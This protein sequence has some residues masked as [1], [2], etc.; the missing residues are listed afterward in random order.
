MRSSSA[1]EIFPLSVF[2]IDRATI[3]IERQA[4]PPKPLR[5]FDAVERHLAE[6]FVLAESL[7]EHHMLAVWHIRKKRVDKLRDT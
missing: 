1:G 5:L 3:N 6:A 7:G 2:A 4:T